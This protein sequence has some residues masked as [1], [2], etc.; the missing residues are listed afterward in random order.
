MS[1]ELDAAFLF[2]SSIMAFHIYSEFRL[3]L[4][5]YRGKTKQ[6]KNTRLFDARRRNVSFFFAFYIQRVVYFVFVFV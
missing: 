4:I 1:E 5:R 6:N 3:E 2:V